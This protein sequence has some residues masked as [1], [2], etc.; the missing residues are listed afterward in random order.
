VTINSVKLVRRKKFHQNLP[1][2]LPTTMSRL[3]VGLTQPP[4]QWVLQTFFQEE[5]KAAGVCFLPPSG[6]EVTSILSVHHS[7]V[8]T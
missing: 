7:M 6:M 2:N 1:P 4:V 3:A 8:H 5:A